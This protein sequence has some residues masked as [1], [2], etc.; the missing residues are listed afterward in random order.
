MSPDKI[1]GGGG[2]DVISGSDGPDSIVGGPGQDRLAGELGA[3][4]LLG[5]RRDD[6][7]YGGRYLNGG[8]EFQRRD[9]VD[10]GS[11]RD[12]CVARH[13]RS[14]ERDHYVP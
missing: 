5:N 10:G 12:Y 9:R 2:T 14:C 7:L 8:T 13:K 1:N 4:V 11:G 6:E 3:D